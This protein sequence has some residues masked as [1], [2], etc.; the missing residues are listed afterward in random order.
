MFR[1]KAEAR[2]GK[3]GWADAQTR[4]NVNV[5]PSHREGITNLMWQMWDDFTWKSVLFSVSFS[6]YLKYLQ[7]TAF[8][9]KLHF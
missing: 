5:T 1:T 4:A 7:P 8:W 3:K 9:T 2:Q 6:G